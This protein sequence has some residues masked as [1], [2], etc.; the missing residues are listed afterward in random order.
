MVTTTATMPMMIPSVVRAPRALFAR[1]ARSAIWRDSPRSTVRR[2]TC[3]RPV[4]VPGFPLLPSPV[5]AGGLLS[6]RHD[7]PV[8]QI[9]RDRS[10]APGDDLV[11]SEERRVGK[12]Y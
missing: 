11:R 9:L 8:L 3:L 6:H 2:L 5:P 4:P 7:A 10:I 12:E 1:S